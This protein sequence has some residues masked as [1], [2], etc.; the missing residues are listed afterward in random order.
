[1]DAAQNVS[2]SSTNQ[3]VSAVPGGEVVLSVPVV[4]QTNPA[5]TG[6]T[7]TADLSAL[8]GSAS[9]AM[10]DSGTGGDAVAGDG[11]YSVTASVAA[12]TALGTHLVEIGLLDAEGRPWTE[13]IAVNVQSAS[14]PSNTPQDTPT[15]GRRT[16]VTTPQG[17]ET[18]TAYTRN[19]RVAS[20]SEPSGDTATF[21][22][23]GARRMLPGPPPAATCPVQKNGM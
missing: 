8:G 5:S 18:V 23:H 1:M 21:H 16:H 7:A 22:Y 6:I 2:T 3:P 19:V 15:L 10:N 17:S 9:A 13:V 20:V 12:G 14:D 4:P 11:I